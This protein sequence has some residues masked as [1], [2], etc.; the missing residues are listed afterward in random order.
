MEKC[1]EIWSVIY[2][3]S[4]SCMI[5]LLSKSIKKQV[6]VK[7]IILD[8]SKYTFKIE[9]IKIFISENL[10]E[11]ISFRFQRKKI[12]NI[13]FEEYYKILKK[14]KNLHL[15]LSG[16]KISNLSNIKEINHLLDIKEINHLS[17][18]SINLNGCSY[19]NWELIKEI[20]NFV[21]L[22]E[23]I[24][25]LVSTD[26]SNKVIEYLSEIGDIVN[27]EKM[28]SLNINIGYN[29]N[30]TDLKSFRNFS[31]LI[32]IEKLSI[33]SLCNSFSLYDLLF[34]KSFKKL[35]DL[36]LSLAYSNYVDVG[37]SSVLEEICSSE[38]INKLT[39]DL[40]GLK[41]NGINSII[42]II[43]NKSS[44]FKYFNLILESNLIDQNNILLLLNSIKRINNK[45]KIIINIRLN[46]PVVNQDIIDEF[47]N[48]NNLVLII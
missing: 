24:I 4:G 9:E 13:N 21:N 18:L 34:I 38:L 31:K 27:P 47:N 1:I 37:N 10:T 7:K 25:E 16:S 23:F 33:S 3:F 36:K 12:D 2:E 39:L 35:E 28:K 30:I 48:I 5:R 15:N 11:T 29:N 8:A 26:I 44:Y 32:N 6:K 41:I 43:N 19:K 22:E 46:N 20:K 40:R 17:R 42:S 14:I 45:C